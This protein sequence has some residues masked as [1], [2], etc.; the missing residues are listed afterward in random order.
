MQ[1]K[2]FTYIEKA[3]KNIIPEAV[4]EWPLTVNLILNFN[5]KLIIISNIFK[6]FIGVHSMSIHLLK[7]YFLYIII[8]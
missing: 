3:F 1:K 4:K 6:G 8:L 7:Y 5:S 2:V